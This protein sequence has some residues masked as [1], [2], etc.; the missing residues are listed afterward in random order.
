MRQAA[1]GNPDLIVSLYA[2]AGC[3]GTIR[4]RASLGIEIPVISTSICADKAVIDEVGD[5]ALGWTF[6]GIQTDE[7]TPEKLAFSRRSLHRPSGCRPE[8][9]DPTALGLGGLGIVMMTVAGGVRIRCR[10]RVRR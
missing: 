3:I 8:E 10:G 7:D 1:E 9:V 2:D 6:V 4:G 5:D